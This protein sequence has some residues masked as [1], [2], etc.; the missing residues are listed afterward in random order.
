VT[1]LTPFP[2]IQGLRA[3]KH[4]KEV[5]HVL[6]DHKDHPTASEVYDRVKK[7]SPDIVLATVYN[8][9]EALVE[10]GAVKQVNFEREPSRY[11]PNLV[12]HGHFHDETSGQIHD[13]TF[14]PNTNLADFL[15]LPE[16]CEVSSLD[17][18][19]RGKISS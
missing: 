14:K 18:T 12:E 4:R 8:C 11:C 5:Y 3:T 19:I 7:I 15:N 16:G 10:R 6:M 2:K 17:I 9:L 1:N 13:V